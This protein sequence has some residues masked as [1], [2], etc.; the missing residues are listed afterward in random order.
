MIC[1]GNLKIIVSKEM[2]SSRFV[3]L[4]NIKL[5][6]VLMFFVVVYLYLFFGMDDL[7]VWC[8]WNFWVVSVKGG[9]IVVKLDGEVRFI[10]GYN[11]WMLLYLCFVFWWWFCFFFLF[12]LVVGWNKCW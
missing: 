1:V 8:L 7:V 10:D 2:V 4:F 5:K 6:K 3:I 9:I 12:Y 11:D